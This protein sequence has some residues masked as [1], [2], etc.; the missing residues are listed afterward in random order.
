MQQVREHP[1]AHP[2]FSIHHN[3]LFYQGK[4]WL[5]LDSPFVA[6]LLAEF[7]SSPLGVHMEVAKTLHRLEESFFWLSMH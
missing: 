3:L 6:L 2:G 1:E 4:I 5:S 7:H